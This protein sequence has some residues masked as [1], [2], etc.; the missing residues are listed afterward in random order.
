MRDR[1]HTRNGWQSGGLA[2]VC[3]VLCLASASVLAQQSESFTTIEPESA[4]SPYPLII[5]RNDG[6]LAFDLGGSDVRKLQLQLSEPISLAL[7]S[8]E[9]LNNGG[10]VMAGSDISYQLDENLSLSAGGALGQGQNDFHALGSIHCVNGT[11][12]AVSYRASNCYFVD[13]RD[14]SSTSLVNLGARYQL[15]DNASAGLNLFR[16]ESDFDA[17]YRPG[18]GLP[19]SAAALD[20]RTLSLTPG[21][22]LFSGLDAGGG[23]QSLDSELT[24]ID[25]EFQVGVSTDRAGDMVLGLQLTRVLD[26]SY[27]S[28]YLTSPGVQ[29]WTIAQPFDSASLSF[30]WYKGPFSGG[31]QTYYRER[32]DFLGRPS[33]ESVG[34][35]DVHFTWRAPWNASLSVGA[36]N[37]LN[38]GVEDRPVQD[39]SMVDPFESV[40]GRIPYVRYK[41]DL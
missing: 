5:Q 10:M 36:S 15:G 22:P 13:D 4:F 20:P 28:S 41:Q 34:S 26:G 38:S 23:P 21:N 32:V 3:V 2:I 37:V 9:N 39:N 33:L 6:G 7:T 31:V 16:S 11:L 18:R 35:F 14:G 24:G 12:D 1:I 8:G 30:D 27:E 25:L 40:Y 19:G 29:N 17:T